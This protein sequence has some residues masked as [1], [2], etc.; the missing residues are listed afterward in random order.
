[1]KHTRR[2]ATRWPLLSIAFAFS[3][4]ASVSLAQV[5]PHASP[6]HDQ[7]IVK[8]KDGSAEQRNDGARQKLLDAIAR[9]QGLQIGRLRRMSLGADVIRTDRRLD[10]QATRRLVGALR[11]DPRVEYA[12]VD[13]RMFPQFTPNDSAYT[14]G[15]Q[16]H[17][18]AATAGINAPAAW[19]RADGTG[20][21]VAVIDTGITAHADLDDNVVAGYDFISDTTSANDGD[22]RDGDPGDPGDRTADR[23]CGS[24]WIGRNASWHGTHVAGIVAARTGNGIGVAGVA[25]GAKVQ[26]LR[27]L[28][29]CGGNVSDIADA[30]VWA[31][32][33]TVPG[34]PANPTPARTANLS[35][36]GSG[37][38]STTF[39][40]AIDAAVAAGTTVVVAAGN[41]STDVAG[42]QPANCR[43]VIAVGA[44]DDTGARAG[45]S[46]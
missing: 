9:G 20:E 1:V 37:S 38:C 42:Q 10:P 3:L 29:K 21:V 26:P 31:A 35:L 8:F 30:I 22:G 45:V 7:F 2:K 18:Y 43:N 17:Y 39:Q 40:G 4:A 44:H 25:F 12:E 11:D 34:V 16:R 13:A 23:E 27:V 41:R 36:G 6:V 33:G 32:G 5:R 24:G 19:E 14:R 28:G 46:N 15:A